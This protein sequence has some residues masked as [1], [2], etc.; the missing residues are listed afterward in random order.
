MKLTY[1]D[2]LIQPRFSLVNS[3]KDVSLRTNMGR[4]E[5]SLPLMSA[6]MDTVTEEQMAVTLWRSGALGV[7]HRFMSIEKNVDMFNNI[8]SQGCYTFCSIGLGEKEYQRAVALREN[9]CTHFVIDVAH[10]AQLQV[11]EQYNKIKEL[12]CF[13]VVGNFASSESIRE[14][15]RHTN[16][17]PDGFKIGIGPGSGCLT[18]V[19]TGIGVPQLSAVIDCAK[20]YNGADPIIIADGGIKKAGDVAKALAAGADFVMV[21]GMLAGTEET[22]GEGKIR[23][24]RGSASQES[25]KAQNKLDPWRTVEGDSYTVEV[26]GSVKEILQDVE[27]GLRSAFSYVG[28]KNVE[29]FKNKARLIKIS[30]NSVLENGAHGKS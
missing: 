19:K 5:F 1:D 9:Y 14:F 30:N 23:T 8:V 16:S 15:I 29:E 12:G 2:V 11:A 20:S 28:A 26:K 6:N 25:Y 7:L 21:G 27:G 17:V 18:R 4:L 22:P 24:Y 10:G 3:R 13:V